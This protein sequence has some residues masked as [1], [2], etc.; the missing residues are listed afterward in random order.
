MFFPTGLDIKLSARLLVALNQVSILPTNPLDFF[1]KE[2][3]PSPEN[4][5]VIGF[6]PDSQFPIIP[7]LVFWREMVWPII[8]LALQCAAALRRRSSLGRPPGSAFSVLLLARGDTRYIWSLAIKS[9]LLQET[10]L[11]PEPTACAAASS[12]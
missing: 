12:P 3:M 9:K 8:S 10:R 4:S 5:R 7:Y 1:R 11:V 2:R 6:R